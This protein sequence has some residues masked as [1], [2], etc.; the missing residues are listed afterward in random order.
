M[1]FTVYHLTDCREAYVQGISHN[2]EMLDVRNDK[3]KAL[4]LF[5]ST[6]PA[7]CAYVP[8]AEVSAESLDEVFTLTNSIE[9]VW[10]ENPR[11]KTL[12]KGEGCRSTSVGDIVVD[13]LGRGYF[14]ARIGWEFLGTMVLIPSHEALQR[15]KDKL[16]QECMKEDKDG[17][18][19]FDRR[20]AVTDPIITPFVRA[21]R[22][23]GFAIKSNR[24]GGDVLGT[25]PDCQSRYLYT[26]IKEEEEITLC[27]H[28][29]DKA[30]K[31][32]KAVNL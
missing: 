14:C 25:C 24:T 8:V 7:T 5:S 28:C 30:D 1:K 29:R 10:W 17:V 6:K 11:V 32:D 22:S 18:P 26:F 9:S 16:L 12:F 20:A 15:E 19:F 31:A 2:Y 13:V 27:P 3:T 4:A 23:E 21:V